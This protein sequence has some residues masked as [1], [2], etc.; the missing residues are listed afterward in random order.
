MTDGSLRFN[1][2]GT[3]NIPGVYWDVVVSIKAK[4]IVLAQGKDTCTLTMDTEPSILVV[5]KLNRL[6]VLEPCKPLEL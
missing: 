1:Q 4:Q 5:F 2:F 3:G 6:Q